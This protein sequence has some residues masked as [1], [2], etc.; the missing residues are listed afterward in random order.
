MAAGPALEQ[1][2][3]VVLE[4]A[5]LQK[6]ID[7]LWRKGYHVVGP[8]VRNGAV[9]YDELKSAADLP[10]GWTDE[11][12]DATYRL[13]RTGGKAFFDYGVGPDS[14][15][16][17]LHPP[18]LRFW[19]AR[20]E[21]AGFTTAGDTE[22]PPK[23]A[24]LGVRACDLHAVAVKDKVFT[25]REF[26]DPSYIK[27]RKDIFVAAV[28]CAKAGGTCFC[29][30]MNT[31]PRATVGLDLALTEVLEDERHYFVVEVGT[32]KGAGVLNEIPFREA[33]EAEKSAAERV[34]SDAAGQMRKF[35]DTTNIR[36]LLYNNPE[37][38]FW[39]EV[40]DRCLTCG[41]CTMVCPTCFCTAVE[42]VNDLAGETAERRRRW[43][44]CFTEGFSYIHGGSVRTSAKARYRQ[45]MTHKLAAWLDQFGTLGCVGCGRCITW[46]PVGIDITEQ[47]RVLREQD[48]REGAS[49]TVA[50]HAG[51]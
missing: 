17:F 26:A 27:R 51:P 21:G 6:L 29:V 49:T 31:G 24:F 30:S 41:N 7:A 2:R 18:V 47:A 35:L 34:I 16:R 1:G 15:K 20:R 10:A 5:D 37:H 4:S 48:R 9:V 40:A 12:E 46:C 3:Q 43:D 22:P 28:N 23:Y 13:K 8:T 44:S 36:E 50:E 39:D 25:D 11:Q 19:Q 14:L 32:E 45:W 33:T 38:P 42:D